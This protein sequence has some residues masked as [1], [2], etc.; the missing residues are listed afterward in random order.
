MMIKDYRSIRKN[1]VLEIVPRPGK[2][3]IV[4]SKWIYN[5]KHVADG[6]IEKHKEIFVV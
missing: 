4:T 5:M 6:S 2:K 1:D 3:S